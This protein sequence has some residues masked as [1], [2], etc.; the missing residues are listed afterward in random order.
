MGVIYRNADNVATFALLNVQCT[1][2]GRDRGN[3]NMEKPKSKKWKYGQ[4][5]FLDN[6]YGDIKI[7][8]KAKN[9]KM[10]L[11]ARFLVR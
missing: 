9:K 10:G 7:C 4:I 3:Q 6:V 11:C 2:Y 5:V 1:A 8:E